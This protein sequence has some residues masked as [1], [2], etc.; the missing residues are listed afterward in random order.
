[1]IFHQN[2]C[3]RHMDICHTPKWFE[4][5][6]N[7]YKEVST[8]INRT[9]DQVYFDFSKPDC[10]WI[11]VSIYINSKKACSF[12]LSAAFDP[13]FEL[14]MWMEDIV[15][16]HKLSSELYLEAEGRTIIFHYEHI[17]LG[18]FGVERKFISQDSEQDEW[19]Y[20][21]ANNITPDTGLF[22][23]YY[24]GLE[25]IPVVCYCKTK[26]LISALYNGLMFYASRTQ[27]APLIG[28]E[29]YYTFHD[30]NGDPIYDNWEFYNTLKSSLIEWNHDSKV[31]YRCKHPKFHDTPQ[32]L[33]TVHMWA[34]WGDALFWHQQGGCCGNADRFFVDTDDTTIDLTDIPELRQWYDEFDNSIPG[35][36]RT[37]EEYEDWYKRG[38]ELA[39]IVRTKLPASV[40]LFYQWK[41]YPIDGAEW[42]GKKISILVPDERTLI[43]KKQNN[44]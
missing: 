40:D 6:V 42:G 7:V 23:I 29:W 31:P 30:D 12:P 18:Q 13:F 22:Y 20:F 41:F 1:M 4:L 28:K 35:Q 43:P 27:N 32:I 38:W 9:F 3:H 15:N 16:D 33:E 26:D 34:E 21:D 44:K 5:R 24:S 39:K 17:R 14:K 36:E 19:E 2:F 25:E 11:D 37:E 10:G 8:W